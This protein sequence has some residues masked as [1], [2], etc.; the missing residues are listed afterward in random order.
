MD[1]AKPITDFSSV[2]FDEAV[3]RARELIPL[4][5]EEAP[6]CEELRRLSPAVMDALNHSGLLARVY[7]SLFVLKVVITIQ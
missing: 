4:L 7:R 5:R 6:K 2:S 3:R 1:T